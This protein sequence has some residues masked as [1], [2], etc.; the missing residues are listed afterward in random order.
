[1]ARINYGIDFRLLSLV[2]AAKEKL[3]NG[4]GVRRWGERLSNMI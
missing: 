2:P 1:V 3:K 4:K